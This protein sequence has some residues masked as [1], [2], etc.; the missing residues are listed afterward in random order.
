[1]PNKVIITCAVTG[2]I[3]TPSMSPYLP[4]TPKQVAEEAIAA[5]KA[6]AAVLHLH[7]RDPKDGRPVFEPDI[8]RQFLPQ[9]HQA[10]DAVINITTGGSHVMTLEQRLAAALDVSPEMASCNMGSMNFGYFQVLAKLKEFKYGWEFGHLEG[11]RDRIFRNTF[12]DI[13]HI[14]RELGEGHGTKF[15]FECY[16]V[17]HLYTL[18]HFVDRGLIKGM[19]FIQ[20]AL[21]ILGGIGADPEN[22]THLKRI[23]DKLFGNNYQWSVLAAGRHQMPMITQAALMGGNVRVGLEDSLYLS[24]GQ[25]APSNADQV[26]LIR[27]ILENLGLEVA[28]PA[29]VRSSLELKGRE[30]VR[31][32]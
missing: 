23:A 31:L 11:S 18:K 13:E 6:G 10:T 20:F 7:A 25:L 2:S 12:A 27:S 14:L 22:L 15:E 4:L 29:E 21:G 16:D 17:G 1:M 8:F 5:A 3:H 30:R 28:S 32:P 24:R 26:R 19:L 9:I